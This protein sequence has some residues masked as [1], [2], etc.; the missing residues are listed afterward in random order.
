MKKIIPFISALCL[1]WG[2]S[3]AQAEATKIDGIAAIVDSQAILESDIKVRF[4]IIKDR[5][6]GGIYSADVRRQ[7]LT[8]MVDEALQA[9][10]ANKSGVRVSPS[11]VDKSVLSVAKNMGRDL[12]GFQ[13]LLSQQGIDYQRY[14]A[15][16]ENEILISSIKQQVI[17]SRIAITEQEIDD[18]INS[19]Q[20]L[21]Q[22]KDEVHLRHIIIRSSNITESQIRIQA[23]ASNIQSEQDFIDQAVA[24]SDG[25]FA[26]QGGDLGWRPLNQL[27]AL[28]IRELSNN[29]GPLY[30]PIQSNAGFHLLWLIDKRLPASEL[31]QQT[32][33]SHILIRP[34]AIRDIQQT[35]AFTDSL[36]KRLQDGEDFAALAKEFSEDEGSA[37][38][39]GDLDWVAA[40]V[41]VPEFERQMN[42]VAVGQYSRPFR[43]QFGWHIVK[44]DGRRNT[45]VSDQLKRS[46]AEKALT[47]QKQD[48]VLS[49]WLDELRA[50]AFIELK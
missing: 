31:Q 6:P 32:K 10:Y 50:Q 17:K 42:Q 37:L 20:S 36:F 14:R 33:A 49:N 48:Q 5:V 13:Q 4:G 15:Q 28:F 9:N 3:S 1:L 18:F 39:G 46:N 38:K 30:G 21:A 41:M 27:P 45:D 22:A 12:L 47:A 40:G 8:Q 35:Q 19:P 2:V 7:I 34:N 25:Q 44:V 24:H 11:D 29:K 26:I 43:S 23:M 16:V